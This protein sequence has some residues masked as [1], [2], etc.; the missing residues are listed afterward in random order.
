MCTLGGED[1]YG[2]VHGGLLGEGRWDKYLLFFTLYSD[3]MD[4]LDMM[5]RIGWAWREVSHARRSGDGE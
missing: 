5:G 2:W 4:G 1:G 3:V